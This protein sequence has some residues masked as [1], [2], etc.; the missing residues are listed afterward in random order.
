MLITLHLVDPKHHF[1]LSWVGGHARWLPL[2]ERCDDFLPARLQRLKKRLSCNL[3]VRT[4]GTIV[5]STVIAE[6]TIT[7]YIF[8]GT[9]IIESTTTVDLT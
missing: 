8:Y 1:R 7:M 9:N 6:S 3:S 4:S 5:A 2:S